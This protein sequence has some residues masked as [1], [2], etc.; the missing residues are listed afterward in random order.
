MAMIGTG[1]FL[2]LTHASAT[3]AEKT[4]SNRPVLKTQIGDATFYAS[5]FQ[6]RKTAS[7]RIFDKN[8]AMAAHRTYPFGTVVRVTNLRNMRSVNVVIVD[9][10]PYGKNRREGAIIDVSPSAA[11]KLGILRTGQ[12]RVK[13]EVLVWGNGE[14]V[15]ERPKIVAS[16]RR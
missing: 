9:R 5:H 10:G 1:V 8:K 13:L 12:A 14:R 7:G 15:T 4:P 11:E 6:G 3:S 16:A 2:V